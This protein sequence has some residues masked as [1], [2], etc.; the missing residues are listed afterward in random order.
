MNLTRN[1]WRI[2]TTGL[3]TAAL[4]TTGLGVSVAAAHADTNPTVTPAP[5]STCLP[6]NADDTWPTWADGQPPR[7]PGVTVWHDADGWH[8]RVTHNSLHDR[9]FSGEI[10]TTG[11][12]ENLKGVKLEKHDSVKLL[13][14][15]HAIVFRFDNFGHIDGF[16]FTTH[17]APRLE[18][19][20]LTD[21]HRVPPSR[22]AIG[23]GRH[24]P[25]HD[26]FVI[27]RTA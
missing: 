7:S 27:T 20:F 6:D 14:G 22:I 19:G 8:V 4:A 10:A 13:A 11:Q 26:P 12:L 16:D 1:L 18:F 24:H 23:A 21:G 25:A 5:G 3:M 9:V 17:C 15:G 2:G